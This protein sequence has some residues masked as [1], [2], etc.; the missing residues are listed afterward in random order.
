MTA[1]T[2]YPVCINDLPKNQTEINRLYQELLSPLTSYILKNGGSIENA[3]DILQESAL[4]VLERINDSSFEIHKGLKNYVFGIC[5]NLWREQLRKNKIIIY[6]DTIFESNHSNED[7]FH[8]VLDEKEKDSVFKKHYSKL[9]EN[10][11]QIWELFFDGKSSREV[12]TKTGYSENY[13]RKVKF[14]SKK[15]L[16]KMVQRDHRYE[17]FVA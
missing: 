16:I 8:K 10:T 7:D 12:A 11:K 9:N 17:E 3:K 2:N 14:E 15:H 6:T 4:V 1:K 13:V 5:K